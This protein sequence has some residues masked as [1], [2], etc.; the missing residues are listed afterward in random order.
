MKAKF[1]ILSKIH[2][3]AS[4]VLEETDNT[5]TIQ[6]LKVIEE[7]NDFTNCIERVIVIDG[8]YQQR[9]EAK[10]DLTKVLSDVELTSNYW[11][12]YE[13]LTGEKRKAINTNDTT[14]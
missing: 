1:F 5:L 10:N 14:N 7:L 13:Y 6:K 9:T 2:K 8:D 12:V 4:A 11:D 3:H